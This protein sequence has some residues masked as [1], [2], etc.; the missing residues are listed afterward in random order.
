MKAKNS[1]ASKGSV[2]K[3]TKKK[4]P[5]HVA[6]ITKVLDMQVPSFVQSSKP[7]K[8]AFEKATALNSIIQMRRKPPDNCDLVLGF[9]NI[10][11][12]GS[13]GR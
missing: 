10:L 8:H 1:F 7:G 5:S 12:T 4:K 2:G 11:S 6:L 9:R 3:Q 13:T